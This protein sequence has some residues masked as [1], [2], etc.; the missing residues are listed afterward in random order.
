MFVN[1]LIVVALGSFWT[2]AQSKAIIA[3]ECS[4]PVY[5]WSVDKAGSAHADNLI[6]PAGSKYEE[7]WRR[8]PSEDNRGGIALKVSPES[9]GIS[10]DKPELDFAY[11][12]SNWQNNT[13]Y[14]SLTPIT[15]GFGEV[16]FTTCHGPVRTSDSISTI[17]CSTSDDVTL[18]LCPPPA[19]PAVAVAPQPT[20]RVSIKPAPEPT[21]GSTKPAPRR[22][23]VSIRGCMRG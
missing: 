3:N 11:T 1:R 14:V 5:V 18:T 19:Q 9:D 17:G 21:R 22:P 10:K 15:D 2:L 13:V 20:R 6:V 7:A 23:A 12:I 4:H 8:S 16:A